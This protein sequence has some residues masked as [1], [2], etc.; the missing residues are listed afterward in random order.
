MLFANSNDDRFIKIVDELI[1]MAKEDTKFKDAIKNI[2]IQSQRNGLTF[3]E[4]VFML[5]QKDL[6]EAR[7]QRWLNNEKFNQL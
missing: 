1:L 5:V 7:A 6:A 3:Y 2:D 4:M